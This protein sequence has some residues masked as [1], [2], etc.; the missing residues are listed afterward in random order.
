M[1]VVSFLP[2]GTEILHALGAGDALVGRSHECDYP[3]GVERIPVVSK[4]ALALDGLEQ[5]EIDAAVAAR[6]KSGE[7]LYLVDEE[8]LRDLAP[9]VILTQDL[10]QVC[11]PSGNALTRAVTLLPCNP[12]A[13]YLTPR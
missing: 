12:K 5:D 6:M 10:C 2:A 11:A 7:S 8:L 1:R 4:P 9:D 13:G 3:S